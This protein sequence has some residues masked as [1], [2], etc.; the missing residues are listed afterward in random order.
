MM[1]IP[2]GDGAHLPAAGFFGSLQQNAEGC[3]AIRNTT[4]RMDSS[5]SQPSCRSLLE[6]KC[7][8]EG[9]RNQAGTTLSKRA[10]A[11]QQPHALKY[12]L[13]CGSGVG[14]WCLPGRTFL[15]G[16]LQ[17]SPLPHT[18]LALTRGPR[19]SGIFA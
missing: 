17:P 6:L 13:G 14:Q 16:A 3:C 10:L 15:P 9:Y 2:T 11:P 12:L 18:L 1:C 4:E 7:E 8:A 19:G 5:W